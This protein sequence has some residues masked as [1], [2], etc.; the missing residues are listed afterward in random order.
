MRPMDLM[1]FSHRDYSPGRP[2]RLKM[3]NKVLR[4]ELDKT[5]GFF[6]LSSQITDY[7]SE[8]FDVQMNYSNVVGYG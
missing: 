6:Q 4:A 3:N 8:T 7:I 5:G 2:P 1:R